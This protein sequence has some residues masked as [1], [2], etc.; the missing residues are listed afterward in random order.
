MYELHV[1]HTLTSYIHLLGDQGMMFGYATDETPEL[2]PLTVTL[3]H[4]LNLAL[5]EARRSRTLPWLRPDSKTQV[6]IEH[7]YDGGAVIPLRV[8]TIVISTQHS[9]TASTEEIR[10]ELMRRIINKVVPASMVDERTRF[11][12]RTS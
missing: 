9:D 1:R 11:I 8:D 4:K 5:S 10:D 2:L 6:T 7:A 3:A 12:V